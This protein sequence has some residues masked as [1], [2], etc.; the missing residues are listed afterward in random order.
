MHSWIWW[1][2]EWNKIVRTGLP[3]G[4]SVDFVSD[5]EAAHVVRNVGVKVKKYATGTSYYFRYPT[6]V[7]TVL[8]HETIEDAE[9]RRLDAISVIDVQMIPAAF[10]CKF[11]DMH[12]YRG[13]W[14]AFD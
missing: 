8:V 5:V 14:I 1:Y 12:T 2:N 13:I 4:T 10:R 9:Q 3:A 6:N 11:L 7:I